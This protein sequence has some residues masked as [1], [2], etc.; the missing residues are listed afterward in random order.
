MALLSKRR[1]G[2]NTI[3][4]RIFRGDSGDVETRSRSVPFRQISRL[5][6]VFGLS[7]FRAPSS[8]GGRR[9]A[10]PTTKFWIFFIWK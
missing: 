8:I 9:D 4:L 2:R 10:H 5:Y 6:K 7:T 3:R 1:G